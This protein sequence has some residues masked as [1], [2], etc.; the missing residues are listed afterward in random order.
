MKLLHTFFLAASALYTFVTAQ[1]PKYVFAHMVVGDTAAHDVTTWGIDISLAQAAAIDAFALNIAYGDPN[2]PTQVANA[3]SAAAANGY[4]FKLFFSFDYLGGTGPWPAEDVAS[5]LNEY[6]SHPA[7]FLY[8]GIPFVGTFEGPDNAGDWAPGG[9]IRSSVGDLYFVPTWT[10]IGATGVAGYADSIQGAFPW[11]MWPV[12]ANNMTDGNDL[13]WQATLPGKTYMM[14]VSPWFFHSTTYGGSV[15]WVER[16]DDLWA[17]RWAETLD[18]N[19]DFVEFVP[20]SSFIF[21][22]WCG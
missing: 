8:T 1:E 4:T 19:P 5:Y 17:T 13:Y 22:L 18:V 9:T 11:A 10:S 21:F 7:Y 16:G 15:P 3:F 14:G 6:K 2:V 20:S 12:G